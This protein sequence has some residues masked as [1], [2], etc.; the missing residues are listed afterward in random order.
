MSNLPSQRTRRSFL[1]AI[2]ELFSDFPPWMGALGA[3]VGL[4]DA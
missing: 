2:S 4:V 3:F 1:P